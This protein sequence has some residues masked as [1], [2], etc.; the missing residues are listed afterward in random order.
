MSINSTWAI[1]NFVFGP[2][3][4]EE[5][6][7]R[8]SYACFQIG[9]DNRDYHYLSQVEIDG[10]KRISQHLSSQAPKRRR[11]TRIDRVSVT[12]HNRIGITSGLPVNRPESSPADPN[13]PSNFPEAEFWTRIILE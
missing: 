12:S 1:S 7:L 6:T 2:R 11:L 13:I 4:D 3:M 5:V 8:A 10:A 9:V